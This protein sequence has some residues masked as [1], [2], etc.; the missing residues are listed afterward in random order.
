M[1]LVEKV[2]GEGGKWMGLDE[3]RDSMKD[4]FDFYVPYHLLKEILENMV[5]HN[6]LKKEEEGGKGM[7]MKKE[8]KER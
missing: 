2:I 1:D 3:I 6:K 7:W 4:E 5:F 8:G